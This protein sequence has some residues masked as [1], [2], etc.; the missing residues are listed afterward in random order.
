MPE[1]TVVKTI[2]QKWK[3][4]LD[5]RGLK[6]NW[7]AEQI[8]ISPEHFSN[9]LADR[10]LITDENHKKINKFFGTNFKQD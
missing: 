4:V 7:V 1:E 9:I 10:V 3:E 6:Q 5:S 2:G 8:G